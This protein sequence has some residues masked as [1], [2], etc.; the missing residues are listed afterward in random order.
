MTIEPHT[1]PKRLLVAVC[2]LSPQILTETLYALAIAGQPRFV[3]TAIHLLTTGEGAHRARLMLLHPETGR[4][5]R[6]CRDYGLSPIAFDETHIHVITDPAG[7]PLD[8]IRTPD[9]NASLADGITAR[10]RGFT[11]DADTALHVSIAGGR[12]TMGYYAGYA[13]SLFGRPQ[14]R[15]SHVL[16]TPSYEGNPDFFYPTP[17]SEI[18]YTRDNRPLDAAQAEVTLAEIPFI[19]LREEIPARLLSGQSGFAETIDLAHRASQPPALRLNPAC[20]ELDANGIT[21]TLSPSQF[22]FYLWIVRRGVLKGQPIT[23]PDAKNRHAYAAEFLESY[24]AVT[25]EWR[26][27][28]KTDEAFRDGMKPGFFEEKVSRIN[29]ELKN[30]LGERLAQPFS[31]VNRG[32]RGQADYGL[33]LTADQVQ[34][35]E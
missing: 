15:L 24:E 18:I 11:A 19:R 33:D 1:Y 27:T 32:R 16:V 25:G 20:R 26:D 9:E 5:Q 23:R 31:I 4:F 22:A 3:P 17:R 28:D 30:T 29:A 13:L 12:K 7:Q 35:T 6:L 8:D 10:L 21:L 14:D 34:I 2:G